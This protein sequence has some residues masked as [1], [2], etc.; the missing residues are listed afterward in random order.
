MSPSLDR[1]DNG[2]YENEIVHAMFLAY[3][4]GFNRARKE[5]KERL[6]YEAFVGERFRDITGN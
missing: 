2:S 1:R 6:K 3:R 4:A 5:G